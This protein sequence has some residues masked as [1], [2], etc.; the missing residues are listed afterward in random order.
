[1]EQTNTSY[2][3]F[4]PGQVLTSDSLNKSFGYLEQQS[5]LSRSEMLGNG[6]LKGLEYSFSNGALTINSGVA[7]T[8]DGYFIGINSNTTYN[9]V[10]K[11]TAL[12]KHP[13]DRTG[14]NI[15]SIEYFYYK[16][17]DDAKRHGHN[18]NDFVKLN[19]LEGYIVAL[20]VDFFATEETINCSEISCDIVQA[21]Q[22]IEYHPVLINATAYA[23]ALFANLSPIQGRIKMNRFVNITNSINI[24]TLAKK[25]RN[26]FETNRDKI[27][28]M[29][30]QIEKLSTNPGWVTLLND[31][32]ATY[33]FGKAYDKINTLCQ[34]NTEIPEYYLLHLQ[35]LADAINEFIDYY[36]MFCNKYPL[37]PLGKNSHNRII[38]LGKGNNSTSNKNYR[39]KYLSVKKPSEF[40]ISITILNRMYHRIILLSECFIGG[41]Q[42]KSKNLAFKV[43][44][45]NPDLRLGE[46]PIPYYYRYTKDLCEF[47]SADSLSNRDNT[48]D[49]NNMSTN[50]DAFQQKGLNDIIVLQSYYGKTIE[51]IRKGLEK[52][53]NAND[54]NIEIKT[55]EL[56]KTSI[57]KTQLEFL[58]GLFSSS[59]MNTITK[60]KN[61][62][63]YPKN[64]NPQEFTIKVPVLHQGSIVELKDQTI[65]IKELAQ[66]DLLMMLKSM[67]AQ[68]RSRCIIYDRD[69]NKLYSKVFSNK[70]PLIS[71]VNNKK[72]YSKTIREQQLSK[73][74]NINP[75]LFK[76]QILEVIE[77]IESIF[78]NNVIKAITSEQSIPINNLTDTN[79]RLSKITP[80]KFMLF[81]AFVFNKDILNH[82]LSPFSDSRIA[83]FSALQSFLQKQYDSSL[84]YA[85]FI[86]GCRRKSTIILIHYKGRVIKI[87]SIS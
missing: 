1:M 12:K 10:V 63:I 44:W 7:I 43:S 41:K 27:S 38:I 81:Y 13:V 29:A 54:L 62:L 45:Q 19:N 21:D 16:D 17:D 79:K 75:V 32:N 24:N 50:Y 36:N 33:R 22:Q 35:D 18:S 87:A 11:A 73:L 51:T 31:N 80:E 77:V 4:K 8:P 30:K 74:N 42:D 40:T 82:K 15:P 9:T 2:P 23:T 52:F 67:N 53:I 70:N 37:I 14:S 55:F 76:N 72:W 28:E 47:W 66:D 60:F 59:S 71:D 56:N 83:A 3:S 5:R 49:Y 65:K 84:A 58:K 39:Q 34:Y 68:R 64:N 25:T 85:E 6:I 86:E 61:E 57:K 78:Q 48:N 26:L 46:R 20:A 69:E